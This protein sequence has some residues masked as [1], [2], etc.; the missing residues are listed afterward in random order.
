LDA[1]ATRR[2]AL[3]TMAYETL[4]DA[5]LRS[6]YDRSGEDGLQEM[7]E[8]AAAQHERQHAHR[9]HRGGGNNRQDEPGLYDEDVQIEELTQNNWDARITQSDDTNNGAWFVQFYSTHECAKCHAMADDWRRLGFALERIVHVAAVNCAKQQRLCQRLNIRAM[10]TLA[11]YEAPE[12]SGPSNKQRRAAPRIL[13]SDDLSFDTLLEFAES[14]ATL[15]VSSSRV[16]WLGPQNFAPL[17][18]ADAM[19]ASGITMFPDD[20]A[21]QAAAALVCG[22]CWS[23]QHCEHAARALAKLDAV[24][25]GLVRV[26]AVDCGKHS[27]LCSELRATDPRLEEG[28]VDADND[29]DD[30][31]DVDADAAMLLTRVYAKEEQ[32]Q[33]YRVTLFRP[34]AAASSLALFQLGM[35]VLRALPH[36]TPRPVSVKALSSLAFGAIERNGFP[37][38]PAHDYLRSRGV[39]NLFVIF[40]ATHTIC[41]EVGG[42]VSQRYADDVITVVDD[43]DD[44]RWSE[45][46]RNCHA[47][48]TAFRALMTQFEM[49]ATTAGGGLR[50]A[51]LRIFACDASADAARLCETLGVTADLQG[52][53]GDKNPFAPKPVPGQADALRFA[54]YALQGDADNNN[55]DGLP[56]AGDVPAPLRPHMFFSAAGTGLSSSSA[57][58]SFARQ[59]TA[60]RVKVLDRHFFDPRSGATKSKRSGAAWFVDFY[61]PNCLYCNRIE[62]MWREAS[63]SIKHVRFAKVDCTK[64]GNVCR[65]FGVQGWPALKLF[66]NERRSAAAADDS[67]DVAQSVHDFTGERTVA[68]LRAFLHELEHPVVTRLTPRTFASLVEARGDAVVWIVDFHAPWCGVCKQLEPQLQEIAR[69]LQGVINFGSIDCEQHKAFCRARGDIAHYPM[70]LRFPATRVAAKKSTYNALQ[71]YNPRRGVNPLLRFAMGTGSIAQQVVAVRNTAE[72][73]RVVERNHDE[74]HERQVW[75]LDFYAD[76]CQHCHQFAPTF[77]ALAARYKMSSSSPPSPSSASVAG[78]SAA[79]AAAAINVR[80]AKI[81]CAQAGNNA[82]CKRFGVRQFPSVFYYSPL[83]RRGKHSK[84]SKTQ[85]RQRPKRVQLPTQ[86]TPRLIQQIEQ[87]L[88]HDA[89]S[90]SS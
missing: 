70:V 15:S 4:I 19:A 58:L 56:D 85:Q 63:T 50:G 74:S 73:D 11:F 52:R 41:P 27:A 64:H 71:G 60:A 18:S 28:D 24:L 9:R 79:V 77:A 90:L 43:A 84:G 10:P 61:A 5:K 32:G 47:A 13:S 88:A 25:G 8:R 87:Q 26:H 86:H 45:P 3:L 53:G 1:D 65:R 34:V 42:G 67:Q 29:D 6:V 12:Q 31:D 37:D 30:D 46:Q 23:V 49:R 7:R 54:L 44:E 2:F 16:R 20:D 89:V 14:S 76:W 55:D 36:L 80:F 78:K 57:L 22:F 83:L 66:R 40:A 82:L 17:A 21:I 68:G 51:T 62:P 59:E 48:W 35:R 39:E 38:A 69:S 72:F 81:D 33:R 75:L